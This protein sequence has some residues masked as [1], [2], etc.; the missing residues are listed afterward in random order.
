MNR[1]ELIE[2]I[3]YN[4]E[5]ENPARGNN[6][7]QYMTKKELMFLNGW[8]TTIKRTLSKQQETLKTFMG[9]SNGDE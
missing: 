1:G 3:L 9:K 7:P 2:A 6:S 4:V 8:I 5:Y